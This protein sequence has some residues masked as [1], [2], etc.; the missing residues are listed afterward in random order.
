MLFLPVGVEL[1]FTESW[2]NHKK[3]TPSAFVLIV[4]ISIR[5]SPN[6]IGEVIV[7]S[8]L[9]RWVMSPFYEIAL[10]GDNTTDS[11]HASNFS[12]STLFCV[13][14]VISSPAVQEYH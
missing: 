3:I 12:K 13:L 7:K 11:V 4:N 6:L 9:A 5:L 1:A 2:S 10:F 14:R 8:K